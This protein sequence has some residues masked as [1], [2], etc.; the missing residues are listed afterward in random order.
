MYYNDLFEEMCMGF[1]EMMNRI[2]Q[3]RKRIGIIGLLAGFITTVL[4]SMLNS[5]A[6]FIAFAVMTAVFAVSEYVYIS[7]NTA[8]MFTK[9]QIKKFVLIETAIATAVFAV[10]GVIVNL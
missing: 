8:D 5:E 10:I 3:N 1:T 2:P 4:C 9:S 7:R 6:V